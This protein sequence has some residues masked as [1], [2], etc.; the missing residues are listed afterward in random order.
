MMVLVFQ[1]IRGFMIQGGCPQ[2][3]EWVVQDILLWESSAE[4]ELK[5]SE[6]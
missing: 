3:M 4:M 2:E 6:A 1:T 5:Q